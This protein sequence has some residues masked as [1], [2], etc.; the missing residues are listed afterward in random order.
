MEGG[1][2]GEDLE[3]LLKEYLDSLQSL[4]DIRISKELEEGLYL[5]DFSMGPIKFKIG[6]LECKEDD[7]QKILGKALSIKNKYMLDK[8]VAVTLSRGSGPLSS[9]AASIEWLDVVS[10]DDFKV[11]STQAGVPSVRGLEQPLLVREVYVK[12]LINYEEDLMKLAEKHRGRII[13]KGDIMG[14]RIAFIPLY[15]AFLHAH[16]I[17]YTTDYLESENIRLCF[18]MIT[19]SLVTFEDGVR[20]ANFWQKVGEL[21][22][23]LVKILH[24]IAD[25]GEAS[26]SELKEEFRFS[27][28]VESAIDVL[29]ER[30]LI[31]PRAP[32]T[33]SLA[34]IPTS[35][36]KDVYHKVERYLEE[37]KPA[38]GTIFKR[39]SSYDKL[40][41]IVEPYGGIKD[42]KIIYYP[43]HIIVYSK[44]A[45]GRKIDIAITVDGITGSRL[46]EL[47]ELLAE[48][49]AVADIDYIVD[50]VTVEGG[51]EVCKDL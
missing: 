47:E 28:D 32:D 2:G 29:L 35:R 15:C 27:V 22:E 24:R 40:K 48:S 8:V 42:E 41:R 18:E 51:L 14:S 9:Q 20:P 34:A 10:I 23:D 6:L 25:L 50:K 33:Y 37:G 26:I 49:P 31:E 38:C 11:I 39:Y 3:G 36:I 46:G 44:K 43:L 21:N 4:V 13:R 19:G 5:I 45:G 1:S 12:P 16:T 30:G 17:D 7:F